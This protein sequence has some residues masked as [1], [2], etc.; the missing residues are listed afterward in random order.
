MKKVI[1]SNI[2]SVGYDKDNSKMIVIFNNG[3]A[4]I[5]D[6]VKEED[7]NNLHKAESVGKHLHSIKSKYESGKVEDLKKIEMEFS[8]LKKKDEDDV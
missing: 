8:D 7:F 4:Y 2:K 5:Y 1:S 6:K 3:G